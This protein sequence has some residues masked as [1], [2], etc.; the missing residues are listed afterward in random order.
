M[1]TKDLQA[2]LIFIYQGLLVG[3][4]GSILGVALGLG[5]LYSFNSYTIRP[6]GSSLVDLYIDYYFIVRSWL[7]AVLA[8]TL[9]GILPARKSRKLTPVEVIR[10][11]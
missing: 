1:G 9:A 7:I 2:S 11:G 5:L 8:S 10:E 3:L 4:L 6:D